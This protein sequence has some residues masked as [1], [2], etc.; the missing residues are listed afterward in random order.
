MGAVVC[1][2][3]LMLY[4]ASLVSL[5]VAAVKAAHADDVTRYSTPSD[6]ERAVFEVLTLVFVFLGLLIELSEFTR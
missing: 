5:T 6:T 3:Y 2:L 4:L 1:R